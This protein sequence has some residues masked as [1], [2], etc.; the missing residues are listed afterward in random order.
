MSDDIKFQPE[1]IALIEKLFE[2]NVSFIRADLAKFKECQAERD[3]KMDALTQ[4]AINETE[5]AI[6]LRKDIRKMIE[7][8]RGS[9]HDILDPAMAGVH[10]EVKAIDERL[11]VHINSHKEHRE[12]KLKTWQIILGIP[13]VV[14]LIIKAVYDLWF[15][16]RGYFTH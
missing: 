5:Q 1:H 4:A 14:I 15:F 3:K 16:L 12:F 7:D 9:V 6:E 10:A 8:V 2:S 11:T 13:A